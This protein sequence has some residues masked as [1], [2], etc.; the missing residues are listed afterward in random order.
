MNNIY[1]H[2]AGECLLE[3]DLK[4]AAGQLDNACQS[5]AAEGWSYSHFLG[6]LL[7]QEV[8]SRRHKRNEMYKQLAKFPYI[9]RL[10]D[11]DYGAQPSLDRR[12]IDELATGRYLHEARNVVFLG[13]SG[14]GKTHLAIALGM[15]AVEEGHRVTFTTAMEMALKLGKA[16]EQSRLPRELSNLTQPRLLIIDEIGY[17]KFD[18]VQASLLFQVVCQRYQKGLSMLFTSNKAFGEWGHIFGGDAVMAGAALDRILHR[19]MIIN[20]KGESYRL[21][22]KRK[23]G[24]LLQNDRK[25]PVSHD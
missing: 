21:K 8:Q 20:I 18:A 14:V 15:V 2:K 12:Q 19:S 11:F 13:P 9:K 17:L 25:E 5:A 24:L 3:L 23:A 16:V 4:C 22:E 1:E 10:E 6:Y 7:N